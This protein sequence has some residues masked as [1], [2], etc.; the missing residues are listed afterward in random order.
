MTWGGSRQGMTPNAKYDEFWGYFSAFPFPA[1][2]Y[3]P[4]SLPTLFPYL[5][6][7][8]FQLTPPLL[9]GGEQET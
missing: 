4:R 9:Q 1:S 5:S 7:L 8:P 6:P 3:P 2:L